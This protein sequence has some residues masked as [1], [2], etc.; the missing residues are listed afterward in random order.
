MSSFSQIYNALLVQIL[1]GQFSTIFFAEVTLAG[2]NR[3]FKIQVYVVTYTAKR[4]DDIIFDVFSK[5]C[6]SSYKYAT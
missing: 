2:D 3:E 5:L 6:T 1:T 4:T